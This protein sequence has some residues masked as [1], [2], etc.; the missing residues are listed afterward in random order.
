MIIVVLSNRKYLD[1]AG[2]PI[3]FIRLCFPMPHAA[4]RVCMLPVLI[5]SKGSMHVSKKVVE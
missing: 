2:V 1:T 3:Y 5:V 4:R